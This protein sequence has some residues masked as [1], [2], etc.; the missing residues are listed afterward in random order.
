MRALVGLCLLLLAAGAGSAGTA[1]ERNPIHPTPHR[2]AQSGVQRI[3]LKL[4]VASG[5]EASVP[6]EQ[7]LRALAARS[8]IAVQSS[9]RILPRLH[10]I[11]VRAGAGAAT[12]ERTLERLRADA[13]VQYAEIDA[14]RY[15]QAVPDDPL[16]RGEPVAGAIAEQWYEQAPATGSAPTPSAVDAVDAWT[17]SSGSNGVVIADIDTGVRFE[18][19]D[20]LD[21][22]TSGGVLTGRLLSGYCFISDAFVANGV[23]CPGPDASDPGDWITSAD[24]SGSPGGECENETVQP[25]TWHGMR[26][27]GILGALTNNA[28]GMAGLTWNAWIEPLRALG[29]CG[30]ND[31]D[32]ETAM[33]WAAGLPLEGLPPNPYPARIINMSI[34]APGACP[35]SYREV[36]AELNGL[37]VLVVASAGNEGGPVDAPANCPGVAAVA[38][39][40]Q[41]GTKVGYSN[42][43]PEVALGAPAG[44]CVNTTAGSPCLYS[45][46]TVTNLGSS[47]PTQSGYTTDLI[48]NPSLGTSFS[49]PIV[50][51]IAAL[52]LSSNAHLS[53]AQ[54]L[55]RLQR[56]AT[57]FPQTSTTTS[58]QCRLPA[59]AQDD[60]QD[61]ECICS[62]SPAPLTCGAGMAN[63]AAAVSAALD[64]IAAIDFPVSFAA[65]SR[66]TLSGAG[67][68]A[69]CGSSLASYR[70]S[71]SSPSNPVSNVEGITSSV[72][73]PRTGS[74]SVT[75]TVSDAAGRTDSASVTLYPSG[76]DSSTPRQAANGACPAALTVVAI[77]PHGPH[78][79]LGSRVDFAAS[80]GEASDPSVMWEVN[81]IAGGDATVGTI[82]GEGVYLAPL[83]L[84]PGAAV[85]VSASSIADPT[86]RG[87]TQL[88]LTAASGSGANASGSGTSASSGSA[89]R[90][91]GG[92]LD[93]LSALVAAGVLVRCARRR[94]RLRR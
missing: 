74:F 25:S 13:Q 4:R 41:A 78:A 43:G 50:S 87:W 7:R 46:V 6:E 81:G 61:E 21:A 54:L 56:S 92:A 71:S 5:P 39:L 45:I 20:L 2:L 18:H 17:L 32:I 14:R 89:E 27:A 8:G 29:R 76:A 70:W 15:V 12:L 16:Y 83:A 42:L 58:T 19:P 68:G 48:N 57:P 40:R 59:N 62:N 37:G 64:P 49:A 63:A 77:T 3:I 80:V 72:Q 88:T 69:A 1:A 91:G 79:A 53:G 84:P 66:V 73:A 90:G 36:M 93:G 51:G 86:R 35:E 30:G 44:N 34:G 24:V 47:T 11:Q 22:G 82:S 67:S 28:L 60:S 26:T 94:A 38:G 75:L 10:V 85:T 31:S 9:R 23:D 52:M 55:E 33:L 65:G